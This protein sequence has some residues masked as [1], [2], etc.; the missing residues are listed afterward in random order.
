MSSLEN[1]NPG[2][3]PLLFNQKMAAN[4]PEKKMPST[5][6][7]ATTRSPNEAWSLA[8]HFIAHSAFRLIAGNVSM[9]LNS[10]LCSSRSSTY[11]SIKR[12]YL[13]DTACL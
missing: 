3:T 8:L 11:D 7:N 13:Y 4:E 5:A 1:V 12:E 9:A 2:R 6:A 10:L